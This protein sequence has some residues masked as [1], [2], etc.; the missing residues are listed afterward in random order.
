MTCPHL[1]MFYFINKTLLFYS[2]KLIRLIIYNKA[3]FIAL[4]FDFI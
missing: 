3:P 2:F 1:L 4:F